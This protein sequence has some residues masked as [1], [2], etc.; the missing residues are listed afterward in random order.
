MELRSRVLSS[1]QPR[2]FPPA[3]PRHSVWTPLGLPRPDES[4]QAG[5]PGTKS[6]SN[7]CGFAG[8][9]AAPVLSLPLPY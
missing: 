1:G 8:F 3:K 4:Q 9:N 2:G 7:H 5:G 6:S